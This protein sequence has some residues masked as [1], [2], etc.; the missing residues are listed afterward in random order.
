MEELGLTIR[1]M[2]Q[3]GKG[4]LAAD[5]SLPTIAKRF[6][7]FGIASTE[8]TRRSY[9]SLLFSS[10]GIEEYISGVI[11]FE[12]TLTQT[13]DEGRLLPELLSSKGIVSGVK[14]DRGTTALAG[15][16]GDKITEGLDGL[17]G[18][19]ETYKSQGARFAKWREVYVIAEKN[20]SPLA[21]DANAE[22]LARYA[23]ICQEAGIVP[24]VEPEV[25]MDGDHSIERCFEVT[26]K[27]LH[28]VFHALER[29]GVVL[30]CIVLKPSMVLP[31]K[32]FM[33][34]ASAEEVAEATVRVLRRTVPASVPSI[35]FLSGGQ[36]PEEATSNLNAMNAKFPAQPWEIS[37]S[38]G[39]AL[40][41]TALEAWEGKA[42]NRD[43]MQKAFLKRARLNGLARRGE[44]GPEME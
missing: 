33:P 32:T 5:E 23:M 40:Q 34:R 30:E 10:T 41:K 22:V 36:G 3:A 18:R 1:G 39:R 6:S 4:I 42:E 11:L 20:P 12:E 7:P 28:A 25:L 9:R 26:E 44:Y 19:L 13:D 2:V 38:Y 17:A 24:I 15:S 43:A 31:G 37:F 21:I 16:P 8:E 29:H 27:V 35:N 14:V